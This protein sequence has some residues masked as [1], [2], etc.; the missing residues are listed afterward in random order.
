MSG[1]QHVLEIVLEWTSRGFY[2]IRNAPT[3]Y[4]TQQ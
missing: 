3:L 1:K 2:G 4:I